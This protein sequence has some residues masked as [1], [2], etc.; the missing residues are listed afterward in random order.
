[1]IPSHSRP[2]VARQDSDGHT[3]ESPRG[4]QLDITV[5]ESNAKRCLATLA[6][7]EDLSG[8]HGISPGSLLFAAMEQLATHVPTILRGD[9]S[10]VWV[11]RTGSITQFRP[12]CP[13]QRVTLSGF[14][15][16][17]GIPGEPIVVHT[18]ACDGADGLLA[19]AD[20]TIVPVP[21]KRFQRGNS[22]PLATGSFEIPRAIEPDGRAD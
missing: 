17:D 21:R 13:D 4:L 12:G 6:L 1:M 2:V 19:E 3:G 7:C 20:Y 8:V 16:W 22:I 15:E 18:E 9:A 14:I 5:D 10:N 11:L